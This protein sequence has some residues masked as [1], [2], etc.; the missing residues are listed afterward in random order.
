MI[1]KRPDFD[2]VDMYVK[3][4]RMVGWVITLSWFNYK[5]RE[6]ILLRHYL[7]EDCYLIESY[8]GTKESIALAKKHWDYLK[9]EIQ[10]DDEHGNA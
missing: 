8:A 9:V 2:A 6:G 10:K 5:G 1:S 3:L 4:A 7:C